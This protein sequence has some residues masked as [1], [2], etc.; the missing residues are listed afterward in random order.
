[1]SISVNLAAPPSANRISTH[2]DITSYTTDRFNVF[3]GQSTATYVA[4][5]D[6]GQSGT[7]RADQ[8][9]LYHL[10]FAKIFDFGAQGQL[11]T[12]DTPQA[13]NGFGFS[14]Q[15]QALP[16]LKLGGAYNKTYFDHFLTTTVLHGGG[17]DYWAFG[18][19][20]TWRNLEWGADYVHQ[21]NGDVAFI[22]EPTGGPENVAIGFSANGVEL[23]SRLKFGKFAAVAG[24][25]DYIPFDLSPFINPSFKTRYAVLGAEWHFSP[26][27]YVFIESRLGDSTDAQGNGGLNAGAIGF[28]YDFNW[29]TLH[30]Q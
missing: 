18:G 21:N 4:N 8:T 3:G 12:S 28:R 25:D 24:F 22:P 16:G 9:I 27:G 15:A 13:F 2:Y 14:F 30:I 5:T 11:R 29:K 23:Y 26:A 7:G 6:G 1:M 17:T 10:K 20:G 19:Q